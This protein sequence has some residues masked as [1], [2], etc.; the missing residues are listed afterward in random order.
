MSIK[1][2]DVKVFCDFDGTI[3]LKDVGNKLFER[4]GHFEELNQEFREG[5]LSIYKYWHKLCKSLP[6]STTLSDLREQAKA[7][8]IDPYFVSFV[9]YCKDNKLDLYVVSD[10][11]DFYINQILE[12]NGLD[13]PVVSNKLIEK[14][15]HL[16]PEY[17]FASES[18]N[19]YSAN[20]KRNF[21]LNTSTESSL[22][23]YI[24]DGYS[25]F[26]AAEHCDIIFAKKYL[27]THCN[28][29]SLPHYNFK[30]FFDVKR[31]LEKKINENSFK[32]RNRATVN[33]KNA[34]KYE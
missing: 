21:V 29:N 17:T 4:V 33:A 18:C 8:D 26:C 15:S 2:T 6:N 19:C 22:K 16:Q 32:K 25:D 10:G 31:I 7:F 34:Y 11:F 24:G 27:A 5:K 30:T 9:E 23:I 13:L 20:C 1:Y 28:E 14:E 3:T 12:Q